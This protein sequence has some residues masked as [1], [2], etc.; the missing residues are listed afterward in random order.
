MCVC[1][2]SIDV[3]LLKKI[4]ASSV[5][6]TSHHFLAVSNSVISYP[7]HSNRKTRLA[8]A[9]FIVKSLTSISIAI[10]QIRPV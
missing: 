10:K 9:I 8:L 6:V 4:V 3:L 2:F 7:E 1:D 5:T